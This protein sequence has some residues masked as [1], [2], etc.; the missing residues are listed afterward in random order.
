MVIESC[1]VR[2]GNDD[3]VRHGAGIPSAG[4]AA[5]PVGKPADKSPS[6]R[7]LPSRAAAPR[8]LRRHAGAQGGRGAAAAP[9]AAQAAARAQRNL[10]RHQVAGL[11]RADRYDRPVAARQAR[12]GE[13]ARG[14]PR[15]RQ[16][17]HRDQELR[18]VDRRAG[19]TARGHLQRRAR[20]R[21]A[22]A[23]AGARRH[24]R[25][26]GQRLQAGLHRGQRQGRADRHPLPRQPAAPQHLP[27][28]RQPGR[29][30]RRR[31]E[32]D[33]RRA[34]ARRLARQRHRAAARHR[35]HRRSP[36]ASSRRTS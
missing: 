22:G 7:D 1:S 16:R 20:L 34:P 6:T 29:P 30:P 2:R 13:R 23:A 11:F 8:L 27:A 26:H 18:D 3:G 9:S 25:H 15:H 28:H 31:I 32:P 12:A 4:R 19:G 24:R 35:R 5:A 21:S 33:L 14:N 36:S 10:L 17:H